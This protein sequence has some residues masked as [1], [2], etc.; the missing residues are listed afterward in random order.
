MWYH[1]LGFSI[2]FPPY[3][4]QSIESYL[5]NIRNIVPVE[6][7]EARALPQNLEAERTLLGS[8]L[9]D[10]ENFYAATETLTEKDFYRD[11]HRRIFL[12]MRELIDRGEAIDLVTLKNELS[13]VNSLEGVGV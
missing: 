3:G 12:C 1:P 2:P 8:I 6:N 7:V 13:R 4:H 10:N 9:L 5:P 11:G